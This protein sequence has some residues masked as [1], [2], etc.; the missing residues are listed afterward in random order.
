MVSFSD[1]TGELRYEI[2]QGSRGGSVRPADF[3]DEKSRYRNWKD[4][5]I[6]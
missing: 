2:V 5:P 1:A 3:S 6:L 4:M